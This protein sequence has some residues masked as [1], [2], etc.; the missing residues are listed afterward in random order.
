MDGREAV[1]ESLDRLLR[2]LRLPTM[3]ACY[4]QQGERAAAESL[5]YDRYLLELVERE[6]EARSQNRVER[7]LR[8]SRLPLEKDL[9][10]LDLKRLGARLRLLN[11]LA[12]IPSTNEKF[13]RRNEPSLAGSASVSNGLCATPRYAE[14]EPGNCLGIIT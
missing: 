6:S 7:L 11:R 1:V 13:S 2:Y 9:A 5:G 8:Q 12:L 4:Q 10:S 3:R 14:S